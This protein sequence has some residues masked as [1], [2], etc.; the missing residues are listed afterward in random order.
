MSKQRR[1]DETGSS[2]DADTVRLCSCDTRG[3]GSLVNLSAR[4][5][6][7]T[8]PPLK[9][10]LFT[11]AVLIA[12]FVISASTCGAFSVA[13]LQR[14]LAT[15]DC[16]NCDLSGAVLI[17]YQLPESDLSGAN[18]SGANLT[19]SWLAG[20]DLSDA[21]LSGA[22]LISTSL[23]GADLLG[24]ILGGANLLFTD[25]SDARWIDGSLCR[26]PSSGSCK[27]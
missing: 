21:D 24:A 9:I 8:R 11:F 4:C 12:F 5:G 6:M 26:T 27:P 18:L 20:A 10:I 19:D 17:H 2:V 7:V 25:L 3:N 22:I 16:R 13:D 14:L 1:C 23:A 15:G